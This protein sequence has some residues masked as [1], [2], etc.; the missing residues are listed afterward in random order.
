MSAGITTWNRLEPRPR[1]N[2]YGRTLKAEVRDAMW[3]LSR[4]WQFGELQAEDTGSAIYTRAQ[5][6]TS[7]INTIKKGENPIQAL[8][9]AV[10]LETEVEKEPITFDFLMRLE[11]GRYWE[12]LLRKRMLQAEITSDKVNAVIENFRTTTS[13]TTLNFEVPTDDI[14]NVDFYSNLAVWQGTLAVSGEKAIDGYKLYDALLTDDD[15]M[16]FVSESL[17][18]AEQIVVNNTKPIFIAWFERNYTIP[19]DTNDTA[20]KSNELEYQFAVG[21]ATGPSTGD[22]LLAEEYYHGSLDWYAFDFDGS[23]TPPGAFIDYDLNN[24]KDEKFTVIPSPASFAGMPHPRWWQ[25]ED[26]KVDLGNVNP[27]TTDMAKITFA[28]FGLVYSNDWM[29][30]PYTVSAGSICELK[31]IV[32]TD[33]FGNRTKVEEAN[34]GDPADWE[35]WSFFALTTTG[36]PSSGDPRLFIPPVAQKVM[37]SDPIEE[38]QFIRDEMANMVWGI[39]KVIPD[40]FSAGRDGYESALKYVNYLKSKAD[41][42]SEAELITNEATVQ[43]RLANSVPENWI[44]FTPIQTSALSRQIQLQRAAMPRYIEGLTPERVRPRTEFLKVNYNSDTSVWD[45]YFIHEDEVPRAGAILKKTWQRTRTEDGTV[46]VWIGK[47]K[48]TGKGEGSSNLQFDV[49]EDKP[50]D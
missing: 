1:N 16:D 21:G 39:E 12:K 32:V 30:F 8:N 9:G 46:V 25:M 14:E 6:K 23:G 22:I 43:Y 37:Q 26:R 34:T 2:D 40:G 38:V 47:Q 45:K 29:I 44:P 33:C 41:P 7:K 19:T 17:S 18:P 3:M 13:P 20:W 31:E 10:P 50:L 4:Q 48:T 24:I 49:L 42:E 5:M 11:M 36:N 28:E 35:R 27:S 15:P